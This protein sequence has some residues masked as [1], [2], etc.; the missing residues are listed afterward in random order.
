MP[1][2]SKSVESNFTMSSRGHIRRHPMTASLFFQINNHE[3]LDK[4]TEGATLFY[5][6]AFNTVEFYSLGLGPSL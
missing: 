3:S 1:I 5:Y 4:K 6:I 2:Q